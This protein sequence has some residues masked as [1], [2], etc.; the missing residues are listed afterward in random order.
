[1]DS[2]WQIEISSN[3]A[4]RIPVDIVMNAVLK[5][6]SRFGETRPGLAI[7]RYSL[8]Q[9]DIML[10]WIHVYNQAREG[11]RIVGEQLHVPSAQNLVK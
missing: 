2:F 3:N 6:S 10:Y 4:V 7:K 11:Y 5:N 1:M 9:V 8:L